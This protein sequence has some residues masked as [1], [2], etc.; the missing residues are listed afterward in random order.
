MN[1]TRAGCLG[2]AGLVLVGLAACAPA[3]SP[4]PAAQETTQSAGAPMTQVVELTAAPRPTTAPA[5]T[6][7]PASAG[8]TAGSPAAPITGAPT[9]TAARPPASPSPA[10]TTAPADSATATRPAPEARVVELEWPAYIRLGDSESVRLALV[11]AGAGYTLTAEFPDNTVVTQTVAVAR[12]GGYAVYAIA[13]LQGAGF[14][15]A[16]D[17]ELVSALPAGEPLTWRWTVL[18]QAAG[19][20]RLIVDLRLRWIG[21]A[22]IRETQL[23]SRTLT[24]QVMSWLG[25]TAGQAL[26]A[27]LLGL[28]VGGG[29]SAAAFV[30]RGRPRPPAPRPN[31][32]LV[33]EPPP[34]L[35]LA[36][37]ERGLLQTLF[38]R[39]ARVVLES[40]FRSGYSGA[41]TLLAL[42]IRSDGRADA[43]TIAK[44]GPRRA[45]QR[46][47]L[48]YETYVKDTLP[49]ITA[50]I[51]DA[52]T[53]SAGA[54]GLG[55]L[56]YTFI[57]EPGHRP[58]SLRE[59]LLRDPDPARL[60]KLFD[61]FGP[62]WWLQRRP[63]TFRLAQEYDR[64]LPAHLVLEPAAGR[65]QVE[66]GPATGP[67]GLDLQAGDLVRVA[68]FAEPEV[69]PDGRS[70]SLAGLA[71]PGEPPLRLRWLSLK[72]PE[73]TTARVVATRAAV[74]REAVAGLDLL[75]LPDPLPRLPE[76]LA[77]TVAGSQSVIHGDLN[78]ENALV[79]PG[80]FVWLIDFA[81]TRDGHPLF[82]FA[83]LTAEVIA[84]V[85][86]PQVS[87]PREYLAL[88]QSARPPA[89]PAGRLAPLLGALWQLA[90]RCLANAAQPREF[91]LAL[92]LACL[93]ALKHATLDTHR[94]HL[95]YLT[96]A[97][98]AETL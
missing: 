26:W 60:T 44:L 80:G 1:R 23:Y 45:I 66:L 74:L 38:R 92:T 64:L 89:A 88:W 63:A 3:A 4:P 72:P 61:T 21:A 62:H 13:R 47:Y 98:V 42:P 50:R 96:A 34:G 46:E 87:A 24:M 22:D 9:A 86:A 15:I 59:A 85:I 69:R 68:R 28:V 83:H 20:H 16:P 49:P 7:A 52:P 10:A 37:E 30:M 91:H 32:G 31:A 12:P 40:E 81:R 71:Q 94:H 17:D 54:D 43:H 2:L 35:T 29:L 58:L 8:E 48:N 90:D 84:H 65:P 76:W 82:D 18:P 41:R 55:V 56:R 53:Y 36:A 70:L 6:T 93:G 78:L 51:Q 33:L 79:G 97:A 39:Y 5:A 95:L 27:G 14:V 73:P 67:A 75:G 19:Q 25:L 77:E 11:P 57:A